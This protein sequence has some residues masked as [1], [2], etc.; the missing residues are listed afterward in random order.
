MSDIKKQVAQAKRDQRLL[1]QR[2]AKLR[3]QAMAKHLEEEQLLT[4]QNNHRKQVLEQNEALVEGKPPPKVFAQQ[5][6][7]RRLLARRHLL[8]FIMRN[9]PDYLPGWVHKD[10]C[11]KL[12][13]FSDKVARKESPR[14]MI[15]MP[16]RHG[17]KIA[18]S[19]PILTPNGWVTHGDLAPGDYVYHP[20]GCP[21]KVLATTPKS[22]VNRIVHTSNG[23]SIKCH[24]EHEWTVYDRRSGKWKTVE[25][26]WLES[27]KLLNGT[28]YNIQLPNVEA[29]DTPRKILPVDPYVL[30]VW[31]GDGSI[32]SGL[33]TF[34]KRYRGHI[35]HISETHDLGKEYAHTDTVLYPNNASVTI[36]GLITK[37]KTLGLGDSKF[38][39]EG[40]I[41][42]GTEQLRELL[43]GLIDTDGHVDRHGRVRFSTTT[44][45]LRDGVVEI[46]KRLGYRPYVM[47]A[48]PSLT[49]SGI[50]GRKKVYQVG[51][52]PT[53]YLPLRLKKQTR[54][55]KNPRRLAIT[56]VGLCEPEPG[57]CI[58]VDSPDGLYLVGDRLTPTHNSEIAS[59]NFPAWHVGKYPTHEIIASSYAGSLSMGFSRK[60][61]DLLKQPSYHNLFPDTR[62]NPDSQSVE[63]WQTTKGGG[64]VAAGVGGGITGKGAH[65]AIIDD[66]VKDRS[67]AESE[68][69]RQAVKDWYTSTLYTRLAPGGGI[70]VI[71]C[72]TGDTPVTMAD[73]SW[74]RLDQITPGDRVLSY[75]DG[76][77]VTRE[78]LNWAPQGEDEVFEIKT[79]TSTV[80]ANARHPF[81]VERRNGTREYV[82]VQD[83]K[84]GDKM[85][86]SAKVKSDT[87]PFISEQE[88]WLLGFMFGDGWLTV[89]DGYNYDKKRDKHYPR[90]G[91]VTCAAYSKDEAA[92]EQVEFAFR[93]IFGVELK[94]TEFGYWR[95]ERQ[96]IG[97]WFAGH[98]LNGNAKTKRLPQWLF[99]QPE[100]TKAAFLAGY[101]HADGAIIAD[102]PNKGRWTH[103]SCNVDLIRDVR[104]LARSC[105]LRV[106]NVSV[107]TGTCQPPNSPEPVESIN[108]NV[109]WS[110]NHREEEEFTATY[111]IRSIEPV[112]YE[113]VYDIQVDGTENFIAD[114]LVSHNT[115]WHDDDLSGWLEDEMAKEGDQWEIIKYPAVATEDETHRKQGEALH[116]D[117][118]DLGRLKQI[119]RAVGP[120]DWQALYQQS[121]TAEDGDYFRKQDFRYYSPGEQPPLDEMYT[122]AAWDMAIGQKESNDYTAGTVIGVD[123]ED[124]IWVLHAVHGRFGAYE[125][126][127][128]IIDTHNEWGCM[129]TGLENGQIKMTMDPILQ[130]RMQE[131]KKYISLETLT[132]GR[133]DKMARARPIQARMQQGKVYFPRDSHLFSPLIQEMLR[134]PNGKHDDFVDSLAWIGQMLTMFSARPLPPE[135]KKKSW[136]DNLVDYISSGNNSSWMSS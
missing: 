120:R 96:E 57:Q 106:S 97:R 34:D 101:N 20:S 123:R 38:I 13:E 98:G 81:L 4:N 132:P 100:Q 65:I 28:R 127:D 54:V 12:E 5:E 121:P 86:C 46:T 80:K 83:L 24:A 8:P 31:L 1:Q 119:Q 87:A 37:L 108:A 48:E 2:E 67:D 85:V 22:E 112:G 118:Y 110:L 44:P 27:Q 60:V 49:S 134:F 111:A 16:P 73:G 52:Q 117:R 68:T 126:A 39:P 50:Q 109:Q 75:Q 79:G 102:G 66:P 19:Q 40:Y 105:G 51:F 53:A 136:R 7:A 55:A 115:R 26:Q 58:Q 84:K 94:R 63:A 114:G 104:Q 71:Q 82:R 135:P 133:A 15:A 92:D 107:W 64:Y 62:L 42:A 47:E 35:D 23:D 103:G 61:R 129:V 89:R 70:L 95:T 69:S 124:N 30:G 56:R 25:T 17:K 45:E 32:G 18:D 72:M 14:M 93:D 130:K 3:E 6:I 91:Y 21:V 116:P 10:I 33:V 9:K 113:M 128:A 29:L 41:G 43:A 99:A 76:K 59:I 36:L 74:R 125:M 122:Y 88:A 131:K 90:R 78:V 11:K 77:H